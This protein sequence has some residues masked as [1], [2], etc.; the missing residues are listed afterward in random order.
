ML[1]VWPSL[2]I[3]GFQSKSNPATSKSDTTWLLTTFSWPI[4]LFFLWDS[5]VQN[6]AVLPAS[7]RLLDCTEIEAF[8]C[9]DSVFALQFALHQASIDLGWMC[10]IVGWFKVHIWQTRHL[11]QSLLLCPMHRQPYQA[12]L[13]FRKDIFVGWV[14]PFLCLGLASDKCG[15]CLFDKIYCDGCPAPAT[16]MIVSASAF[17]GFSVLAPIQ[18][19]FHLILLLK[20]SILLRPLT[21]SLW[22]LM[23][24]SP[25]VYEAAIS[26]LL[27]FQVVFVFQQ[28]LPSHKCSHT[29][30]SLNA[31]RWGGETLDLLPLECLAFLSEHGLEIFP[32]I[33]WFNFKP[34][35][36]HKVQ[37]QHQFTQHFVILH[38]LKH[39][40]HTDN[41]IKRAT[42]HKSQI[43][44]TFLLA[45]LHFSTA[46]YAGVSLSVHCCVF[47]NNCWLLFSVLC[48][49]CID[50]SLFIL[51]ISVFL[52]SSADFLS[53]YHL[54][55]SK[56]RPNTLTQN[57]TVHSSALKHTAELS[58]LQP[59][60]SFSFFVIISWVPIELKRTMSKKWNGLKYFHTKVRFRLNSELQ[61]I[62]IKC[63]VLTFSA[64]HL[65][66]SV[67][68]WSVSSHRR[69]SLT[70]TPY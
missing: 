49:N 52:Y 53:Y 55:V 51:G 14:S 57:F 42:L 34:Y 67:L 50:F 43:P 65:V 54:N 12:P 20:V 9:T 64:S 59:T 8:T 37:Y 18:S 36:I 15:C 46:K 23:H 61:G 2:N 28:L 30:L 39:R 41:F 35:N 13:C 69:V 60:W 68:T 1:R 24:L 25:S 31:C 56:S 21:L 63:C 70:R 38:N 33:F 45:I 40:S 27:L 3:L 47:N 10:S 17:N 4:V 7:G 44:E 32:S 29:Y 5:A 66:K 48:I 22:Q 62:E 58:E 11:R 6:N 26:L 16:G 19:S